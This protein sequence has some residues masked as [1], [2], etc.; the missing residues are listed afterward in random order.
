MPP[1]LPCAADWDN[2]HR[3]Y[4]GARVCQQELRDFE[5][6]V[7]PRTGM[8]VVDIGCGTGGWTRQLARRWQSD[9]T[10]YDF[11]AEALRQARHFIVPGVRYRQW[12]LNTAAPEAGG[13]PGRASADVVTCRFALEFLDVACVLRQAAR[14][15]RPD[16][17]LYA[18]AAVAEDRHTEPSSPFQRTL[19]QDRLDALQAAPAWRQHWSVPGT[20]RHA[21]A[22]RDPV[23]P[24]D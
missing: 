22:L 7:R 12:D 13:A 5:W 2:H 8:A 17:V 6:L 3:R 23:G 15:L 18:L 11:S 21:I 4:Q 14:W 20:K 16:G 10:G 9:V 24:P 1:L 19:P